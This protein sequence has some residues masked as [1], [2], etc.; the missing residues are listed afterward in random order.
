LSNL[1]FEGNGTTLIQQPYG[2]VDG[3]GDYAAILPVLPSENDI[4]ITWTSGQA[5]TPEIEWNPDHTATHASAGWSSVFTYDPANQTAGGFS[6]LAR[7]GKMRFNFK[8]SVDDTLKLYMV[9]I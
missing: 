7:A 4:T 6:V 2:G 3:S 9:A 8:S 5:I 1:T